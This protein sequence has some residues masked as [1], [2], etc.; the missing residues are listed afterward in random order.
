M[1]GS[2]V[3]TFAMTAMV[4]ASSVN[5]FNHKFAVVLWLTAI[6]FHLYFFVIF[7]YYRVH[8]FK[9]EQMLPSWFIPPIGIVVATISL[10]KGEWAG[11][12][13]NIANVSLLFGLVMYGILLPILLYRCFMHSPLSK[14]EQPTI[15]IFATPASLILVGYL[16]IVEDPNYFIVI[17]LAVLAIVMTL[18][19]Y[20]CFNQL[21]RL[22]FS[23]AYAAFTFPLVMGATAMFKVSNFLFVHGSGDFVIEMVKN[24]AYIELL[25]AS[26]MVGYVSFRYAEYFKFN[27]GETAC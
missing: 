3:P 9:F 11:Y 15:A 7:I 10:P 27:K 22:P 20:Y 18:F 26:L 1:K 8:D 12:L 24:I 14:S 13:I 4:I 6:I 17:F 21:L 16:A 5:Y 25:L 2:M 19:I 23:P